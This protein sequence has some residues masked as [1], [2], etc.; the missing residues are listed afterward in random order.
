MKR[1]VC[2]LF[3]LLPAACTSFEGNPYGDTLRTLDVRLIYPTEYGSYLRAGV[4]VRLADRNT[5][6]V[7][8]ALTDARG[9]AAFRVA[10]GHYRLSSL[11]RASAEVV[12]NGLIEQV[13]LARED[14]ALTVELKAAKPGS[15]LIKE[16]YSGGC[17]V[18]PPATGTYKKDKYIVLHNNSFET[19][20]LDGLCLDMVAPYNSNANNP[21]TSID[22]SGN[23]L[24]RDY[25][26]VPDCIW[27]FP[28]SG[29]D[30][31]LE[32]GEDAVVAFHGVDHTQTYS[33]S[34]NLD[35]EGCFVLYDQA[36]YPGNKANPTPVPG[37]RIDPSHYLKV[38][39]KTGRS[40]ENGANTYVIS[41][42]S[43][44]VI[45]FRAPSDVDLEAY[46]ADDQQSTVQNSS[47][48]YSKIP[49]EWIVDGAEVCNAGEAVRNK[50]L[51]GEVDAGYFGFS[52]TSLG[53]TVHRK[54]DE[55]A[56]GAAGFEIL[57]D[58]NNSSND[59]YERETQSLRESL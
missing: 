44:A 11:D 57:V 46:L 36:L 23:I 7:Y 8:T 51:H 25:A 9:E 43:P 55:E 34:V 59:F 50:R 4:E 52:G 26:A 2:I 3:C 19:Y 39:K 40:G 41:D 30:F 15:I 45:L 1:I 48:L 17:P 49:W 20:Y 29:T 53:H 31:P 42:L 38:L 12:F 5:S 22:P 37:D 13:D 35:R 16:I 32:P 56:S 14:A 24:F 33:R 58:T 54:R 18:D 6:N 28:G 10:A 21:W 47:I 27:A